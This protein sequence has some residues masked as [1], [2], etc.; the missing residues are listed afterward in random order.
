MMTDVAFTMLNAMADSD[1]ETALDRHVEWGLSHL[2]LKGGIL[3]KRLIDLTDDEA[4]QAARMVEERKLSV[5]CLST[6]LFDED[7]EAGEDIFL[8]EHFGKLDRLI[9]IAQILR[10][11]FVRLLAAKTSRRAEI[12]DSVDYLRSEQVWLIDLYRRAIEK[13]ATAG[14]CVT[15]EN[16]CHDCLMSNPE[17]I[18]GFFDCLGCGDAVSLTWD[19]QNLWQMGTLPTLQIYEQL[20]PLIS[21]YHLK[22]G[23]SEIP[24][25]PLKWRSSLEDASWPVEEITNKV[26]ADGVSP[27]ICLNGSHG[28]R[29]TGYDYKTVTERDLGFVKH[30]FGGPT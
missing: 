16:E 5:Y 10:P 15:V 17:E 21:Y 8:Q 25:G 18:V 11:H 2:D 1:F 20:K 28:E 13:L 24:D 4:H 19:V 9:E 7:I 23:Q 3:G 22:G 14:C 30:M 27:V 6:T 12:A 29:K 26:I